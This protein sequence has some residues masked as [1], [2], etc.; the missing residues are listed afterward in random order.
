MAPGLAGVTESISSVPRSHSR[1]M[2]MAP[3]KLAERVSTTIE[4]PGTRYQAEV[5]ASLN[6][7]R[8]RSAAAPD[9]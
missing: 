2:M 1:A 7:V 5:L 3:R 4:S 6:H 8:E 9:V